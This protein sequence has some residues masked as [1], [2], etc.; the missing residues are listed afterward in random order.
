M[1]IMLYISICVV[2]EG[3]RQRVYSNGRYVQYECIHIQYMYIKLYISVCV[4]I[5]GCR[6]RVYSNGRYVQYECIHIYYIM[7]YISVCVVNEGYRQRVCTVGT[8]IYSRILTAMIEEG[9]ITA[10]AFSSSTVAAL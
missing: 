1:Y 10:N 3:C 9:V 5:E 8:Y 7:L 4:V 2:N 6:Q